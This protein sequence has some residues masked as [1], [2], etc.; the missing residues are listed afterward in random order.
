MKLQLDPAQPSAS[1]A[2]RARG[3][4]LEAILDGRFEER[5]PPE[6]ELAEMLGVSRTSVRDALQALETKGLIRRRRS[7]G[8]TVNAHFP[9]AALALD[10]MIGFDWL[11]RESGHKVRVQ[12]AWQFGPAPATFQ[13]FAEM[14][15]EEECCVMQKTYFADEVGA[16]GIVDAI[17]VRNLARRRLRK[18]LPASVFEFSQLYCRRPIDHAVVRLLP[19]VSAPG[20]AQLA[21]IADQEA[22]LRLCETHYAADTVIGWSI[23]DVNDRYVAFDVMRRH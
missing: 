5:L 4:I 1:V 16:I 10:R 12:S 11:L 8:T 19:L 2:D 17:P 22:F 20:V 9:P 15:P 6:E 21:S 23:I 14:Q 18:N 13:Q 3:A 7:A